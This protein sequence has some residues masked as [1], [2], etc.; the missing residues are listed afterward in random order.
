MYTAPGA[1]GNFV[2]SGDLMNEIVVEIQEGSSSAFITFNI[3]DDLVAL[4]DPEPYILDL[5][6][7]T[8]NPLIS[9]GSP[10]TTTVE[11]LD[12]DGKC[13]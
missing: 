2:K 7:I 3:T 12:D 4:E 8:I 9:I 5:Q 13:I 1:Q 6:L 10:E 11:I